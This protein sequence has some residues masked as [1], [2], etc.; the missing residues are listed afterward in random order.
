MTTTKKAKNQPPDCFN[1]GLKFRSVAVMK[2]ING[3]HVYSVDCP[4]CKGSYEGRIFYPPMDLETGAYCKKCSNLKVWN[5]KRHEGHLKCSCG[6]EFKSPDLLCPD[7]RKIIGDAEKQL[8]AQFY[9]VQPAKDEDNPT[10]KEIEVFSLS[11][12]SPGHLK[13]RVQYLPQPHSSPTQSD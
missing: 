11:Q 7:C 13:M 2:T 6:G 1:V 3:F 9:L 5:R 12:M 4:H 10:A 8:A